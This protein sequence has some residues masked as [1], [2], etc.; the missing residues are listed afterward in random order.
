MSVGDYREPFPAYLDAFVRWTADC[1]FPS[2]ADENERPRRSTDL[3]AGELINRFVATFSREAHEDGLTVLKAI[4]D[5][6]VCRHVYDAPTVTDSTLTVLNHCLQR[7]LQERAFDVNSWRAGEIN[8]RTL[9][10]MIRSFLLVSVE[11]APAAVRYARLADIE[12]LHVA[13]YIEAL[14]KDFQKPTVKQHSAAI[15]MLFDWLVTGQV[16]ATNPAHAAPCAARS[17]W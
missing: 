8:G 9:P 10:G 7:M 16:V 2:W 13:A 12:P 4:T 6:I 15:R 11:N 17:M 14:G 5:K 1:L 3:A